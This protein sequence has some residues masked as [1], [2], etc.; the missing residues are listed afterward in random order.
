MYFA[1]T[2]IRAHACMC[3][4]TGRSMHT[5]GKHEGRTAAHT[6]K[7]GGK[8]VP[9]EKKQP[10]HGKAYTQ[11]RTFFSRNG[12]KSLKKSVPDFRKISVFSDLFPETV[13]FMS[14]KKQKF[15]RNR[16]F[17]PTGGR[18]FPGNGQFYASRKTKKMNPATIFLRPAGKSR[19]K[20][21]PRK[22]ENPKKIPQ[23]LETEL[24]VHKQNRDFSMQQGK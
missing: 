16:H 18:K 2:C 24:H 4:Q 1:R 17:L 23:K 3:K 21:L 10:R 19:P 22:T 11:S 6:K 7:N 13:S 20:F 15:S 12:K 5:L 14:S 9:D 8:T